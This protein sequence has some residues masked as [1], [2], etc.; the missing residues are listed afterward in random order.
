M[1][2]I[3]QGK[4]IKSWAEVNISYTVYLREG[5]LFHENGEGKL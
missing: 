5:L 4:Q 3:V 2:L 1:M